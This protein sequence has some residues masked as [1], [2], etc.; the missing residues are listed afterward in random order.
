MRGVNGCQELG[1]FPAVCLC[2]LIGSRFNE[3]ES[4]SMRCIP[5]PLMGCPAF[6]FIG[7]GKAWVTVEG[8]EEDEKEKKSSRIVGLFFSFTWVPSTL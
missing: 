3:F 7:Q 8:K 5:M 6:P 1:R 2:V 4:E